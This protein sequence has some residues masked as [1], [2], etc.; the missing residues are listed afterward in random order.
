MDRHA[1]GA[2]RDMLAD[3]EKNMYETYPEL[4]EE[5]KEF[6]TTEITQHMLPK[7]V[8]QVHAVA[9]DDGWE[10]GPVVWIE[11]ELEKGTGLVDPE[12]YGT[13]LMMLPDKLR[14]L[15]ETRWPSV[16]FFRT[17]DEDHAVA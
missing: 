1:Q 9:R 14:E 6:L 3:M 11:V 10:G 16:Q 4:S 2:G 15:G 8:V 12:T 5:V 7:K 13:L 17:K